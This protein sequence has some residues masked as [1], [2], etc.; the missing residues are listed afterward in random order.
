MARLKDLVRRFSRH[1]ALICPHVC[2]EETYELAPFEARQFGLCQLVDFGLPP[3][4][5]LGKFGCRKVLAGAIWP[6]FNVILSAR[7]STKS[8]LKDGPQ[9]VQFPMQGLDGRRAWK[10][11][12][13]NIGTCFGQAVTLIVGLH[14]A[15]KCREWP[16]VSQTTSLRYSLS[17]VTIRLG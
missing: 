7:G 5:P 16:T 10:L 2:P 4:P 15:L 1:A 14:K 3:P 6:W 11:Y 12:R 17:K 13:R 9:I 8:D